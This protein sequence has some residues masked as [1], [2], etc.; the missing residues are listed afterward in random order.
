MNEKIML[1][2]NPF[3]ILSIVKPT[4]ARF[5]KDRKPGDI[6]VFGYTLKDPGR[7]RGVYATE[8]SAYC[9]DEEVYD[10]PTNMSKRI[11]SFKLKELVFNP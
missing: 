3:E 9:G 4:K 5:W 11:K 6:V 2:S 7:N 8:V 10:T 1:R